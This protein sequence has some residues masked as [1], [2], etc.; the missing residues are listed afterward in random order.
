VSGTE[1]ATP[2]ESLRS[3]SLARLRQD[4]TNWRLLLVRA[5]SAGLSV[6]LTV[7]L[8]PGLSFTTWSWGQFTLIGVVFGLLNATIKPVLQFFTLRYLVASYGFVIILVNAFLLLLLAWILDSR[9]EVATPLSL[10]TGGA[11]VGLLGLL[12]D[13][14]FGTNRPMLDRRSDFTGE[15][16]A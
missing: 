4:L 1:S 14:L 9:L 15:A 8:L 7:V 6:V 2:V 11:L 12:F 13:T 5:V 3:R 16:T 10:L